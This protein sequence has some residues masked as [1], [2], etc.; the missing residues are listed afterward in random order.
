MPSKYDPKAVQEAFAAYDRARSA[1]LAL[2]ADE[3]S[4]T[5]PFSRDECPLKDE[6]YTGSQ[7]LF[8]TGCWGWQCGFCGAEFEE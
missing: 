8:G 3:G 1:L 2:A 4:S 6:H 7:A 5:F